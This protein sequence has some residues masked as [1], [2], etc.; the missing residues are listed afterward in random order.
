METTMKELSSEAKAL[1]QRVGTADGP[2]PLDRTRVK[3]R[4]VAGLAGA[5][6]VFGSGGTVAA[7][8]PAAGVVGAVV[9]SKVT[10]SSVALW[11]AA[12][13]G[14]GAVVSTP[15]LVSAYRRTESARPVATATTP[16]KPLD[17]VNAG[18]LTDSSRETRRA[19]QAAPE[20]AEESPPPAVLPRAAP[21]TAVGVAPPSGTTGAASLAEE[22]R[23]LHAAQRELAQK[24]TAA[25]LALLDEHA[26]KFP[27]GALAQERAGARVLALC[28]LGRIAEARSAAAAFVRASPHSPLVPRLQASCA[29]SDDPTGARGE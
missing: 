24:R 3:R 9:A 28:D 8:A 17:G 10:F 13:A 14:L 6:M 26:V 21:P 7:G 15:A 25:A 27:R 11:L 22:T 19:E 23:L 4:I 12:G 18:P 20:A 29:G 1:I 16:A 2:S 5:G